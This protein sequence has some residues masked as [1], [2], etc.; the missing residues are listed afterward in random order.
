[1][2]GVYS[3]ACNAGSRQTVHITDSTASVTWG[4]AL[5]LA[6]YCKNSHHVVS[7]HLCEYGPIWQT[8][9]TAEV[10]NKTDNI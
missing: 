6:H 7:I 2:E 1:M 9:M 3:N 5:L 10:N 8:H 4:V